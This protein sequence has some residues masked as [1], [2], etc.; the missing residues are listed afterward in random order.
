MIAEED[1]V[2]T[3]SNRGYIKRN[4]ITIYRS[5]RRGGKGVTA[6]GTREDDF[7]ERL[8]VASTHHMFLFFTNL[9]KVYWCKCYD[10]PQAGRLSLGKAVVNL[11]NMEEQERLT[12]VL[13]VPEFA[14]GKYVIMATK[15]G[16]VKKTDLM[17]YSRPRT[18]GIIAIN[19]LEGDEL[20]VAHITDGTMN[21]FLGSAEGK[22]IRFHESD[23]RPSGRVATGVRGMTLAP[24]EKLVS[25]EVLSYGQTLFTVTENGYGKRTSIDE[26]PVH[27][28]GGKGVIAIKTSARN[29][30]VVASL[31]VND[32]DDV[33]LM[34]NIGKVIRTS[35]GGISVISRNTQGVKLIG[36]DAGERV[37]G[38][39]RLGEKDEDE[40]PA[41]E[42]GDDA[43]YLTID[44]GRFRV[45]VVGGGSWGTTLANLL[46]EKGLRVDLW[47]FEAEVASRSAPCGR[48]ARFCRELRSPPNLNA[49]TDLA[50]TAAGK[51]LVV[52]VVPS[53]VMRQTTLAMAGALG[54][55]TLV[56]S[57]SKGIENRTHLTMTGVLKQTLG[58]ADN[59]VGVLSGPSFAAEV[60]RRMPT[61]VTVASR[62]PELARLAQ[63]FSPRPFFRVYTHEDVM[64]VEL[65]GSVKNVIAIAAGIVDGLGFGLNTRAALITRGMTEIRRLGLRLGANPRTFT[66]LAGFGDLI[67]T[68]TGDLSRNHTLGLKSDRGSGWQRSWPGPAAWPKGFTPPSRSTTSRGS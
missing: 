50:A 56:I 11:L 57:A 2:V 32:E 46:A 29:G 10:I 41:E 28:R 6:M 20:I 14:P 13:A 67:L 54:P 60:A 61:T 37:V 51:D 36:V 3:L 25:M 22:A 49:S 30:K 43:T 24:E 33:M 21:V 42:I 63:A 52:V 34:T 15:N 8:F 53:H 44:P 65:G 16:L 39:A 27:K 17:A 19:L 18:G 9:G 38:A 4:P 68:C 45:A 35:I 1:M 48:T 47:V 12:T 26:Y 66:G 62:N 23:V 7:V 58:I 64:G 40:K 31:V 5:Q 55:E 59:R